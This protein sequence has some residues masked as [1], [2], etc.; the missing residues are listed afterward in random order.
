M[1]TLE[2]EAGS[3]DEAIAAYIHKWNEGDVDIEDYRDDKIE[4][5]VEVV[6]ES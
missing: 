6:A 2:I 4:Y 1:S 3:K 5:V